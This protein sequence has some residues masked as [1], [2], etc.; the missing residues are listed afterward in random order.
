MNGEIR[1]MQIEDYDEILALWKRCDGIGLSSADER[2]PI[3]AFLEHN[4]GLCFVAHNNEEIIGTVLCGSDGRRGYLY[5]LAVDESQRHQGIG[6]ALVQRSLEQLRLQG[7][8]KCHLMVFA[9]NL[10][11]Q[12][13]WSKTGWALRKDILI[14]SLDLDHQCEEC[15]C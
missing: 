7:V 15:P 4:P 5:H 2:E 6:N 8:Q 12:A 1:A 14:M 9:N 11:G 13:F 3:K 10:D